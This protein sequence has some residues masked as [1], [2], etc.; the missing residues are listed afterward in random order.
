MFAEVLSKHVEINSACHQKAE[1]VS[2]MMFG[3]ALHWIFSDRWNVILNFGVEVV[4]VNDPGWVW[5]ASFWQPHMVQ[6]PRCH[7]S[8]PN[9]L[10]FTLLCCLWLSGHLCVLRVRQWSQIVN[11]VVCVCMF[12]SLFF[13]GWTVS[14]MFL[15]TSLSEVHT[16]MWFMCSTHCAFYLF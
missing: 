6:E 1:I 11:E 16:R 5:N 4:L 2:Y 7:L 10:S 8:L 15:M 12:F 13:W 3:N 9:R 14:L